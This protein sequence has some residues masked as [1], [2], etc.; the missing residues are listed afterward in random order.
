M[1]AK[2][3][4]IAWHDNS[5]VWSVDISVHNRVVTASGDKVARVWRF[6][7]S[8]YHLLS[9]QF[10]PSTTGSGSTS[11]NGNPSETPQ[12]A[13]LTSQKPPLPPSSVIPSALSTAACA[14][15]PIVQPKLSKL[16]SIK[17]DTSLVEWL[18][19][20]R[21]HATTINIAR[22]SPCGLSIATAADMG[23]IVLWRLDPLSSTAAADSVSPLLQQSSADDEQPKERWQR[24]ITLRGHVQDVLDLAWSSDGSKLASAS[25]DNNVMLW[26][27]NNGGSAATA[28]TSKTSV[29]STY[30]PIVLRN[31]SNFVQG[32]SI[33]PFGRLIASIG[34][35]RSLRIFSPNS[36]N[37]WAQTANVTSLAESKLF[38][39]D[40]KFKNFFRRLHW[41]PDGSLLACPSGVSV[42]PSTDKENLNT[43][44]NSVKPQRSFAVH[45]FARNRWS[46]P[47]IQCTNLPTP[48][49]SVRFN[50]VLF[51]LRA[52][53]T[54]ERQGLFKSFTYRMI[55]AVACVH[56]VL[57][58]DT[59]CLTRPFA[60]VEGLHCAEQTDIAWSGDGRTCLVSSVDGYVSSICFSETEL[61]PVLPLKDIPSWLHKP[62]TVTPQSQAH[63]ADDKVTQQ[64]VVT[65]TVVAKPKP[66]TKKPPQPE[67]QPTRT[68]S[69][70]NQPKPQQQELQQ[71]QQQQ[72]LHKPQQQQ[73][74]QK[75]QQQQELQQPQ[76]RKK[77][78]HSEKDKLDQERPKAEQHAEAKVSELE[79]GNIIESNGPA[80]GEQQKQ[81]STPEQK[82]TTV[83][84]LDVPSTT[85]PQSQPCQN[86][87]RETPSQPSSQPQQQLLQSETAP[88]EQEAIGTDDMEIDLP[89]STPPVEPA[90]PE[91]PQTPSNSKKRTLEDFKAT[92]SQSC[93]TSDMHDTNSSQADDVV[94][95]SPKNS[96]KSLINEGETGTSNANVNGNSSTPL[97]K[98]PK[99]STPG[100]KG[101]DSKRK[102][103]TGKIQ[104]KLFFGK[105]K[106][107]DAAA[108][109]G[110][111][112]A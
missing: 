14:K 20:L 76:Q 5:P 8:P 66:V 100:G 34:N 59:E 86:E 19:D 88:S 15:R 54:Q 49:C 32:V 58:Y 11:G 93:A 56:S 95:V 80:V 9:A 89:S 106:T 96:Q 6:N 12:A 104:T 85:P 82:Q 60:V 109:A 112:K 72:G 79:N 13:A 23:E 30:T 10:D 27:L 46:A 61:G 36:H 83:I 70:Q 102:T 21:A 42:A 62:E 37:Q 81:Q 50:P 45:L 4:E 22:F 48:P 111:K 73:E 87:E 63:V 110:S 28:T 26:V 99:I 64:P 84:E 52:P 44:T 108:A 17:L 51:Q 41:S 35:D 1:Y 91:A 68:V 53:V 69:P 29:S 92:D 90:A 57:F 7:E 24:D 2:A 71:P 75:P 74:L 38:A 31:H 67:V 40:S 78:E 43:A 16:T 65:T 47:V 77:T 101:N 97:S 107:Q 33:D 18:C 94:E 105:P 3:V 98:K 25:V 103:K 55:F 39:D